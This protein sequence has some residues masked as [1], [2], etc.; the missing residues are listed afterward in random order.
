[1]HT[2]TARRLV[3]GLALAS[4]ALVT[5]SVV[6]AAS[7]SSGRD[8]APSARTSTHREAGDDHGRRHGG[9]GADDRRGAGD[10]H[11]RRHGGHGADDRR[12]AGDDHGRRHGGDHHEAGDDHGRHGRDH[13]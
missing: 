7:A 4:V 3:A 8:D 12:E 9:H 13:G 1:M 10:D 6:S 5:P 2:S 11:G